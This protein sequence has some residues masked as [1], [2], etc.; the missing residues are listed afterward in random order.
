[1]T[2]FYKEC[3]RV[4]RSIVYWLFLAGLA[5]FL[6]SQLA[7][8]PEQF[9]KPEPG[10]AS[11]G[12]KEAEV[13]AQI[14]PAATDALMMDFLQ[15]S[16]VAYPIGF[17]KNVRLSPQKQAD[18]ARILAQL[19]NA[20]ADALLGMAQA[21]ADEKSKEDTLVIGGDASAIQGADGGV[22]VVYP[23]GA[24]Q[25]AP[26]AQPG[27]APAYTG[28]VSWEEFC[29]LM[30]QADRLIG[31]GSYYTRQNMIFYFG[32]VPVTYEEALA[33]YEDTARLDGAAG[34]GVRLFCDYIC[35]MLAL[36]PAF[37]AAAV[38]MQDTKQIRDVLYARGIKSA[39]LICARYAALVTMQFL[40]VLLGAGVWSA[41]CAVQNP[42][43]G[44]SIWVFV[45]YCFGW[46]LPTLLAVTAAGL[47]LTTATHTPVAAGVQLLWWFVD[48][49]AGARTLSSGSAAASLFPRFNNTGKAGVFFAHL[50]D[51]AA[52]RFAYVA[53]AAA[54]VAAAV[55][56][57]EKQRRGSF[58]GAFVVKTLG[59]GGARKC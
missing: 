32:R 51:L 3:A 56:L 55:W 45:P 54:L 19:T 1:M 20:D 33:E 10:L 39:H 15:N 5:V 48:I 22:A 14:M 8:G 26:A 25:S 12:T 23:E 34:G 53:L 59:R 11:Y 17:Y 4:A 18:M 30:E 47:L 44:G 57:Y 6:Y 27:T 58:G 46:L 13:P 50:G 35:I 2:L 52:N 29:A 41:L 28:G 37:T 42:A 16:Y 7:D 36:L 38:A 43:L 40:P 49:N 9:V 31:G 21:A 24:A